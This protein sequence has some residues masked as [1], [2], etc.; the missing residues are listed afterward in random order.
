ML[1]N[2][3]NNE[4]GNHFISLENNNNYI[5]ISC[6]N[7]IQYI[8]YLL[9]NN[10]IILENNLISFQDSKNLIITQNIKKENRTQNRIQNRNQ[11]I[12]KFVMVYDTP[13]LERNINLYRI[14]KI[15]EIKEIINN[16]QV[17]DPNTGK[18]HEKIFNQSEDIM[19]KV[20][21]ILKMKL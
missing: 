13:L 8:E 4:Y 20:M 5:T 15:K 16:I 6:L 11:N 14:T 1:T 18:P 2:D 12:K 9:K 19:I 10:N 17:I 21:R 7:G 3:F